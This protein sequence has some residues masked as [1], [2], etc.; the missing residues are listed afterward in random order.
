M[1]VF[2]LSCDR[3]HRFEGWF[4]DADAFASQSARGLI[5]C[6]ICGS[7]AIT[8]RPSAPYIN[9]RS[10]SVEASA[11]AP[12]PDPAQLIA[13]LRMAARG[14]EDVGERFADEARRMHYG[15]ADT[16]SIRGR[17]SGDELV[18]L[19]EEGIPVLPVPDDPPLQ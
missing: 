14:A 2:D 11:K 10:H 4:G 9:T 3:D 6:P 12:P 18:E 13:A 15:E 19:I 5:E 17:A 1:I 16:R 8:R 7:T